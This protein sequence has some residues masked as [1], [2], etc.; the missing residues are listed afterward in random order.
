VGAKQDSSAH[1]YSRHK[2]KVRGKLYISLSLFLGKVFVVP[3]VED[4]VYLLA[5]AE[6]KF[7]SQLEVGSSLSSPCPTTFLR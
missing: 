2:M 5:T 3:V 7:L 6:T 4:T 1:S